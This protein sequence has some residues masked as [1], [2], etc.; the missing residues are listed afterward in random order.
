MEHT[1]YLESYARF[2]DE[3]QWESVKDDTLWGVVGLVSEVGELAQMVEKGVRK[4]KNYIQED[5]VSELGDI[6][7]HV[8]NLCNHL[9]VTVDQVMEYN[10]QKLVARRA[11]VVENAQAQ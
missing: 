6:L 10:V 5:Y 3:C 11:E 1:D 9:G 2:V 8:T 7:W 4:G